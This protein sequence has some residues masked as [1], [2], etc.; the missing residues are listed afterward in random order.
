MWYLNDLIKHCEENHTST[1]K[2]FW[3]PAKP[4]NSNIKYK[5]LKQRM[6]ESFKVLTGKLD[7]FIWPEDEED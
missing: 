5:K 6:K 3:V 2:N 7:T 4:L 1:S